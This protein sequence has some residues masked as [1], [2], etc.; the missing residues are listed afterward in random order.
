MMENT[1]LTFSYQNHN[2]NQL[3]IWGFFLSL[4]PQWIDFPPLLMASDFDIASFF[5][6]DSWFANFI[7]T[8]PKASHP[9]QDFIETD[10]QL[11]LSFMGHWFSA[12]T[13]LRLFFGQ[14][15][16][17]TIMFHKFPNQTKT[18]QPKTTHCT[19][20]FTEF[21]TDSFSTWC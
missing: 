20:K 6:F 19:P 9:Y 13:T 11:I 16:K 3:D 1:K 2:K 10:L 5:L 7:C 4:I 14:Y 21:Y 8:K 15:Q 12:M 18:T 17:Q